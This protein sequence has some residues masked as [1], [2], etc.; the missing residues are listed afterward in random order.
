MKVH[1][2]SEENVS[3]ILLNLITH[4]SSK[5]LNSLSIPHTCHYCSYRETSTI[6]SIRITVTGRGDTE[7]CRTVSE[8]SLSH[9]E[10][11]DCA[12]CTCCAR[13]EC[14]SR[15]SHAACSHA[16]PTA[17]DEKSCLLLEGHSA[18]NLVD[19]IFCQ[20]RLSEHCCRSEEHSSH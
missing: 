3:S 4:C 10:T 8:D 14:S 7:T 20:F 15:C 9:A 5:L 12:S 16:A 6:V 17:A 13:N 2:W 18:D 1:T 19:I 11:L